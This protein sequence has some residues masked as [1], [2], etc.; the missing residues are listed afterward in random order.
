MTLNYLKGLE[1]APRCSLGP[2]IIGMCCNKFRR[3]IPGRTV[4]NSRRTR[5]SPSCVR[6]ASFIRRNI[7][8]RVKLI[9]VRGKKSPVDPGDYLRA[10]TR[11]YLR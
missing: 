8:T 3:G 4:N 9:V 7:I 2:G 5:G 11:L 10:E 1:S 6:N